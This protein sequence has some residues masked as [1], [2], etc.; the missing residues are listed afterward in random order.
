MKKFM[1]IAAA[2]AVLCSCTKNFEDMN[3]NPNKMVV[4]SVS[5]ASLLPNILYSGA[6]A[7]VSQTYTLSNELMQY[8]VSSNTTDAYHRFMIP[9]GVSASL[10]NNMARWAASA[11]HMESL[12]TDA[13]LANFQAIAITMRSYYM[14]ILTDTFGDVPFK[15]AFKGMDGVIKPSFDS[16]RDVYLKLITDLEYANSLYDKKFEM[17]ETQKSKD[18]L[19]GGDINKW[20]KFTNSLLLRV[21]MRVTLCDDA[22]IDATGRMKRILADPGL[23]PVFTSNDDSAILYFSGEDP[24]LNPYGSTN[25]VSFES[26]RRVGQTILNKMVSYGDPRLPLY[27]VQTGG[28]WK[29]CISG[30]ATREETGASDA[31]KINK[32]MV[33][34]YDSP[35]SLMNYDELLFIISEAA[36]RGYVDGGDALAGQMYAA[37]VEASIRHWSS[38]PG[39]ANP[40]SEAAISQFLGKVSYNGTIEQILDQKYVALFW[41]G[42]ESWA[43]Y[44]RTGLPELPIA[45][46]TMN[47][48]IHP[49]RMVYPVNTGSTNPENY[50]A[51]CALLSGKYH[52]GDDMK[53]PV[54]WSKYRVEHNY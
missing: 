13:T 51:V 30:G 34:D 48:N 8:S 43:D 3:V 41:C 45:A 2:A 24:N 1:I 12:C 10:W 18:L 16:Q 26:S 17:T 25:L 46:T 50:A 29:G 36:K 31:S 15:E 14:Q 23:Y 47:D 52:G 44:R 49:R 4:G 21:L 19:Y 37:G 39:N 32:S 54:W 40:V 5:P 38:L 53:T 28:T 9:N 42:F 33:G 7:L 27:F 35:Y 20:R 11:D 6:S 22:E